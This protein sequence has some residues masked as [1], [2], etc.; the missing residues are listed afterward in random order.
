M[1]FA[2][3]NTSGVSEPIFASLRA[4]NEGAAHSYGADIWTAKSEEML[5]KL[6]ECEL[7]S[8]LVS[9]GTA[10][11]A[12][13]LVS[14]CPPWGG[15]FCHAEAHIISDECGAP[16]MYTAG[17]KL[18]GIS[19]NAGKIG[20]ENLRAYLKDFPKGNVNQVQPAIL[21]LSQATECGTVYSCAEIASLAAI[22]HSAGLYVHVDGARF[23]NAIVSANCKPAEMTWKA[24]VDILSFGATKNGALACE[25]MIFFN[26][27]LAGN[28]KFQRKRSGHT[29]SKGRFLGAQ[30]MAYIEDDHWISLARHANER[31][32]QIAEALLGIDGIRLVWPVQANEIFIII[33]R[34]IDQALKAAGAQYYEWTSKSFD[35]ILAPREEEVFIR[36]VTSFATRQEDI[37]NFVSVALKA[38]G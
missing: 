27:E 17:A 18:I 11:N 36:L 7:T 13:S 26:S 12:L 10:A 1:D 3:D 30:M 9:T 8:F 38:S 14:V 4:A 19:G 25:A 24:G 5:T 6:F 29:V 2:S 31:A 15:V 35:R 23:A 16:E 33:P 37:D 34:K 21:S 28:V 20:A 32:T 22:A